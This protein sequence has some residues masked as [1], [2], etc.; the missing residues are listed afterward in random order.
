MLLGEHYFWGFGV[1]IDYDLAM[2]NFLK[3]AN[4]KASLLARKQSQERI[5]E[6]LKMKGMTFE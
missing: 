4:Q 5:K 2:T 3:A 6:I 1:Q